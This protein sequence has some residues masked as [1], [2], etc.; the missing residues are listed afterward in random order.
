MY[1]FTGLAVRAWQLGIEMRP[2][3]NKSSLAGYPI[4]AGVGA[5]FGYW[6]GGVQ[7]RQQTIL[8]ARRESLLEKRA[9]RAERE[10][11]GEL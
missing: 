4:F 7:E 11:A 8:S 3:F 5:S 1:L 2:F 6:L 9:R 10:A